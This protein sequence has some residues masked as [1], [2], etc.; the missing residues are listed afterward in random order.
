MGP[1]AAPSLFDDIPEPQG[2]EPTSAPAAAPEPALTPQARQIRVGIDD[3]EGAEMIPAP[4]SF[5]AVRQLPATA[6]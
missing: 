5:S 1:N 6:A 2:P 3:E 4:S